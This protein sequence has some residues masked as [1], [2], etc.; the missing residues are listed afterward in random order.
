[1]LAVRREL[2]VIF[3]HIVTYSPLGER[4]TFFEIRASAN[5]PAASRLPRRAAMRD[6]RRKASR[7]NGFA[8]PT[9]LHGMVTWRFASLA[10][11][12]AAVS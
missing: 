8:T 1:M 5:D 3:R 9:T 7:R 6:R 2:A 12:D 10:M 11:N 4:P